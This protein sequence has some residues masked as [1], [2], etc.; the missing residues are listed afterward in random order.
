M[1]LG[2]VM[3]VGDEKVL[4]QRE[5]RIWI[6]SCLRSEYG[7]WVRV[8]F[9]WIWSCEEESEREEMKGKCLMEV[10]SDIFVHFSELEWKED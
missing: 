4:T 3:E 7:S 8:G 6:G 5:R 2:Y 1:R 9:S 10:L